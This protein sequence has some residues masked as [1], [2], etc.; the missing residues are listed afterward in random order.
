MELNNAIRQ[1]P[2]KWNNKTNCPHLVP[3]NFT[4]RR[5]VGG[6]AHENWCLLLPLIIGLK[7]PEHE[8]VWPIL[9]TL[10]DIVDL[11]MSPVHTEESIC[12]LDSMI[13]D[14]RNR[15]LEAFHQGK[16]LPKHHFL[17]HYLSSFRNLA[18]WLPCGQ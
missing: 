9:M 12:Y 1:F 3:G 14:H 10:K 2:Y 15:F 6:N 17:E 13:S 5:S 4:K 11:V 18:L 16:L 7:V 8:P